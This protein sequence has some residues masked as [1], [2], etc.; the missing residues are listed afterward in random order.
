[1]SRAS[2][3]TLTPVSRH[4]RSHRHAHAHV[5]PQLLHGRV[6]HALPARRHQQFPRPEPHRPARSRV[7]PIPPTRTTPL[8]RAHRFLRDPLIRD[9]V[10]RAALLGRRRESFRSRAPRRD[11]AATATI[12]SRVPAT[13]T[14]ARVPPVSPRRSVRTS[15]RRR[16]TRAERSARAPPPSTRTSRRFV[17]DANAEDDASRTRRSPSRSR[18][19]SRAS[20]ATTPATTRESTRAPI[21]PRARR[22]GTFALDGSIPRVRVPTGRVVVIARDGMFLRDAARKLESEHA[23]LDVAARSVAHD[24]RRRRDDGMRSKSAKTTRYE[25]DARGEG[26]DARARGESRDERGGVVRRDV[27]RGRE[28]G[29]DATRDTREGRGQGA[30]AGERARR[31]GASRS[32]RAHF[33]V[34]RGGVERTWGCWITERSNRGRSDCRRG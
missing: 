22:R 17:D 2:A 11:D 14:R 13:R 16:K 29:G 18:S 6:E 5:L 23:R 21:E 1:M 20:P 7:R 32:G 30:T 8:H 15:S 28:R 31:V 25:I 19:R 4:R 12:L 33:R 24:A 10:V 34:A 26:R 27:D 3:S 9:L